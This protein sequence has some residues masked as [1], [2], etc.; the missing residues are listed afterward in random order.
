M[1][2][3]DELRRIERHLGLML[4]KAA[5]DDAETFATIA[6]LLDAAATDGM[7]W[8][9]AKLTGPQPNGQPGYSWADLARPML[10]T[11]QAVHARYG[12]PGKIR[13]WSR[14]ARILGGASL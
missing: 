13:T 10:K 5:T 2:E 8:A 12:K 9:A 1:L 4:R 3:P 7:E 14:L 11:R 6:M